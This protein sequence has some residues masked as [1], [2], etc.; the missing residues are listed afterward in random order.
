MAITINEIES[1]M[2][3][4]VDGQLYFITDFNHVKPGK[5][6]A[7]VRIRLKN[8]RTDAVL[9]R[10]FRTSESLDNAPLERRRMQFTYV[11]GDEYHFMDQSTY[12]DTIIS[13]GLLGDAVKYLQDDAVVEVLLHKEQVVKVEIPTFII[14]TVIE[15]DPGLKGDSSRA[16]Y[17]PAKIDTGASVQVPLFIQTGE[18]IKVDT[19]TGIYVERVKK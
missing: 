3:L 5:G 12:E 8:I 10:T 18:T 15:A 14:A 16:G 2:G 4:M 6:S 9:E 11:S 7:F 17:K 13:K 19:R 1:G